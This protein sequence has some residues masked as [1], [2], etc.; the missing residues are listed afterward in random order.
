MIQIFQSQD[1]NK[2]EFKFK[3]YLSVTIQEQNNDN[4]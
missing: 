1:S 4:N 3:Q 2:D